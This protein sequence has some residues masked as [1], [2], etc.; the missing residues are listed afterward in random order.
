MNVPNSH[1]EGFELTANW[2]PVAGLVISSAVTYAKS[3]IEGSYKNFDAFA[4]LAEFG[5]EPFPNAPKWQGGV[6]A[7]YSW[8]LRDGLGAYVGANVNHQ[9]FTRS[10]FYNRAPNSVQPPSVLNIPKHTLVDLRAGLD[11]GAWRFQAWGRNVT[12]KYYWQSAVHVNDVLLRYTGMP[13]TYGLTVT[14]RFN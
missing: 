12:D 7:Q 8:T 10:F 11:A 1:V 5:G 4:Q 13:R 9:G 3:K 14:Y 2:R 6:D